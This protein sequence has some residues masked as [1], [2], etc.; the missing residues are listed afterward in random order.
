MQHPNRLTF[1]PLLLLC[2][3]HSAGAQAQIEERIELEADRVEIDEK[4]GFSTYLGNVKMS[5]GAI[6]INA[7]IMTVYKQQDQLKKIVFQ[8]KPVSFIQLSGVDRKAVKGQAEQIEY[9]ADDKVVI[10]SE[11]AE[12]WQEQ[13]RFSGNIIRYDIDKELVSAQK[14]ETGHDRVKVIIHPKSE[15]TEP[16][17]P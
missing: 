10:L 9:S 3:W 16:P 7:E 17:G 6:T 2:A 13:D 8:G 1:I 11:N 15:P 14:S 12:L 5:K 4:F